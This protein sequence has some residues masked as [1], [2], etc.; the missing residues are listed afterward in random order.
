MPAIDNTEKENAPDCENYKRRSDDNIGI[1][2]SFGSVDLRGPNAI[3]V[4]MIV[5]L[6]SIGGWFLKQHDDTTN[7]L[8]TE[9]SNMKYILLLNQ[10]KRDKIAAQI[11]MPESLRKQLREP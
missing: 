9:V 8:A 10:E 4:L 7:L 2:T 1:K 11:Q 5:I 6:T 3:A